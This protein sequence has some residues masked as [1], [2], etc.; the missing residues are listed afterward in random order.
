MCRGV[1]GS[2]V[3]H[4]RAGKTWRTLALFALS[5]GIATAANAASLTFGETAIGVGGTTDLAISVDNSDGIE[6][7]SLRITYDPAIIRV[8]SAV[9]VT[10]LT[11]GCML[12]SNTR[13]PGL[14][15]LGLACV[16]PLSGSGPI[17]VVKLLGRGVGSSDLAISN[18]SINEGGMT[19]VPNS[20]VATVQ[21][22]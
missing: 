17:L 14:V 8:A 2:E 12:A 22:A 4:T 15:Q 18:C 7:A 10:P 3:D 20:G 19:C 5:L 6:A 11:A 21:T 16:Q 13:E 1:A 9:H